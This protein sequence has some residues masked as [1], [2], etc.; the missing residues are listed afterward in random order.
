MRPQGT[1]LKDTVRALRERTPQGSHYAIVLLDTKSDLPSQLWAEQGY[2]LLEN[3]FK[4]LHG[5]F[6]NRFRSIESIL[7]SSLSIE[8]QKVTQTLTQWGLGERRSARLSHLNAEE[9][10][11]LAY[12]ITALASPPLLLLSLLSGEREEEAL[13]CCATVVFYHYHHQGW[14][15]CLH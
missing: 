5:G 14:L 3:A 1:T 10:R 15:C 9:Q 7:A 12:A 11:L 6:L 4:H 8:K 13:L 2:W